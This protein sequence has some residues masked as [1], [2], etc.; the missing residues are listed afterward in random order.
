MAQPTRMPKSVQIGA[1]LFGVTAD[2][3]EWIKVE[4]SRQVKGAYGHTDNVAARIWVNPD[5]PTAVQRL[6][7]W[8]EIL[9]AL[10]ETVMGKYDWK[11]LGKDTEAREETVIRCW[12]HPT[13]AVLRDNPDLAAYLTGADQ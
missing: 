12:E 6:T 9:H 3:D 5:C 2:P 13:L 10:A 4:H 8:H 11:H 1:V 7:L